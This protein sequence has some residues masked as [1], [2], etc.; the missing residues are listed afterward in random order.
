M[1]VKN[2]KPTTPARRGMTTRN[3]DAITAKK[4]AK[5]LII[6]KKQNSGRNNQGK[7][8]IRHRGGGV[9]R[10]L[11]KVSF[12]L[13]VG[14]EAEVKA[15][16]YDPNRSAY[17][18]LIEAN[19]KQLHYVLAG[20][21]TKVGKKI[22]SGEEVEIVDGNSLPLRNIPMGSFIYNI[23]LNIGKGGQIARSAGAKAQLVAKEGDYAHV[24]LPSG[25]TRLIHLDC[26]ATLGNV[27]N[28][29]HQNI[30]WGSAGRRRRLGRRPS[31]RGKAMNPADHPMGGGEG[32]S[33]PGRLPRT[34]WGKIAIGQKTRRRKYSNKMIIRSRK[35]GRR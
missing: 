23:E 12:K 27:G 1:A 34:P 19:D 29:Q 16:E 21:K 10:H 4:S 20:S 30:K 6:S 22:H 24:K 9:K 35:A 3:T 33:G 31:V 17:I 28:E 32:L 13:P 14:T 25:E 18:A 2:L 11:R 26:F 8:T 5:S 7:I 15:I